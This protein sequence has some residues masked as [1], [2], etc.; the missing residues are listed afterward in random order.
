MIE[1]LPLYVIAGCAILIAIGVYVNLLLQVRVL[2]KLKRRELARNEAFTSFSK[3]LG[4]IERFLVMRKRA[5]EPL[6]M[7]T[8]TRSIR[9]ASGAEIKISDSKLQRAAR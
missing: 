3:R 4:V 8:R 2:G 7:E 5:S 1:M 9:H 6:S